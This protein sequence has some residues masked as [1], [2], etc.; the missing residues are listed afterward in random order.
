MKISAY[1]KKTVQWVSDLTV[2]GSWGRS[3]QINAQSN[4]RWFWFD[5]MFA[6]AC[7]N[8]IINF[9]SLYILILGGTKVQVGLMSSLSSFTSALM[10]LFGAFLAER[11]GHHKEINIIGGGGFARLSILM[12]IFVPMIFKGPGMVWIAILLSVLRDGFSNLS[13]PAWMSII[14]ETV[15]I[16][17]RGRYFGSR[18]FVM[19]I[20]GMAA[21]LLAGKLITLVVGQTGYQLALGLAFVLGACSLYSFSHLKTQP[22]IR[23]PIHL[24][25]FSFR[26]ITRLWKNQPHYVAIVITAALWNFGVYIAGPFF[27]VYMVQNL[28]FSASVVALTAVVSSLSGLLVLNQIGALSDRLG[29]RKLQ[30]VSMFLIPLLPFSWIFVSQP[31]HV[32]VIN[33]FTGVLWAAYNLAS[34]NLLLSSI[35]KDQ[36]ARYSALYQIMVTLSVAFGALLGSALISRWGFTL[37]LVLS[38][39]FR[40]LPAVLFTRLVHD[41]AK[42]PLPVE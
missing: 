18:N 7:D 21:T 20:S 26:S 4:L 29:P 2:G 13:Y 17:G 14:N 1:T 34:F 5:G 27:N 22:S 32:A 6:S 10:L 41:P 38:T 11:I 39:I 8:I 36:V 40:L 31:W 35:P 25:Q 9:I 19:S 16:E 15:P 42:I 23:K 30:M 12:L 28:N 24:S 37:L 33:I 3:L